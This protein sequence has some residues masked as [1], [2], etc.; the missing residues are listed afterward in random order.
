M[1]IVGHGIDIVDVNRLRQLIDRHGE[2]F[3]CRC[4]TPDEVAYARRRPQRF[5]EHLAA[6]F[7]AKEAVMKVLGTGLRHGIGWCDIEVVR[8]ASG[9]PTLRLAGQAEQIARQRGIASWHLSLS[10]VS[11]HA[12]ASAI[13]LRA[14]GTPSA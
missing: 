9:Q 6:R 1:P 8:L 11:S 2:R 12:T 10:H 4:F 14:E 13:G 3:L 7:A 5:A